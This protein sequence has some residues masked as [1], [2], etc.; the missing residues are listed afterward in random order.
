M[1]PVFPLRRPDLDA[2]SAVSGLK[3]LAVVGETVDE[4]RGHL[5]IY[6]TSL[7]PSALSTEHYK[8]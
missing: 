3:D 4:C 6:R 8:L 7:W 1:L 2:D 5:C